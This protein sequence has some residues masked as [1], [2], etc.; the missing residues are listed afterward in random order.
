MDLKS[1]T[2]KRKEYKIGLGQCTDTNALAR[3]S[4]D[5]V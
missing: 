1:A 4:G 5:N 2:P 3:D